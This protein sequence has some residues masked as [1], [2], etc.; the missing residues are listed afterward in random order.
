MLYL[1]RIF[2]KKLF[3]FWVVF[4]IVS[5]ALYSCSTK[6]NSFISRSFHAV[7]TEYNILFNGQQA[8]NKGLEKIKDNHQD[9][10]WKRLQIEPITFN[11]KDIAAPKFKGPGDGFS[12]APKK[13]SQKA[14][15]PFDRAEEKAVKAIQMHSMNIKGYERNSQ[16]DEAYLLLGKARYYTQRFIPAIEAY[17]YII[18]NYPNA[19]LNYETRVWRAKAN[20]RLGSEKTAIESI[21]LLLKILDD[22]EAIPPAIEEQAHTTMAMAYS[23]TDTIQKV[24]EHLALATRTFINKEQSSRNLFVLGQIY[25]E[26]DRRDSARMV[27]KKLADHKKAPQKYRIHATLE[28]IKNNDNKAA[29]IVYLSRLKK[30]IKNTDN[31]PYLDQLYYQA[32]ALEELRDRPEEAIVY[33]KKSLS[34]N[35]TTNYQKTYA[36]EKLGDIYFNKQNYVLAGSYYD[37]VLQNA[38]KEFD[39][40]KRIRR[41]KRKNKGLTRLKSYED[42]IKTNDSILTLVAMSNEVRISFFEAYIKTIKKQDEERR[43][44]VA[45][46][47]SFGNLFGANFSIKSK[48]KWYF[49]NPQTKAFGKAQF[50]TIWGTR[51]LEDTWRFSEKTSIKAAS[52][53]LADIAIN[54]SRYNVDTYINTIPNN[55]DDIAILVD[56]RDDALYQLGLIYKEQFKNQELAIKNLKRL[57]EINQKEDLTL[58]INYHLYQLYIDAGLPEDALPYKEVILSTYP[59]SRFA[60]IITSPEK[61]SALLV[62]KEDV[63]E[64]NYKLLYY[65]YKNQEYQEVVNQANSLM[66]TMGNSNLIPK[67]ALLKALAIGKYKN[68]QEYKTALEFVAVAYPNTEQAKKAQ[69]IITLIK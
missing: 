48:G 67:L 44:Q 11:D 8:F 25:S 5:I 41:I 51:P 40:E 20:I 50:E 18:A 14:A 68:K 38:S 54:D 24:I 45:N 9:N 63:I 21:K 26:L 47:Q 42:L 30:L 29:N 39:T 23:E 36:F 12:A 61:K 62:E 13:T 6:K 43:Q 22:K 52:D 27:F 35:T 28:L 57:R 10:F 46:S 64:K 55:P 53:N 32:G 33:Y 58:A 60:E 17:N 49:Y 19:N 37:S 66:K 4:T 1:E 56:K 15:S 3:Q 69:E 31:R 7:T 34:A 2:M 65:L 16:I 59:N